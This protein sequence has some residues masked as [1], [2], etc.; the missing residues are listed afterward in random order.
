MSQY[1]LL[2]A[3]IPLS[4]FELFK[5]FKCT[6]KNTLCGISIGLV[7]APVGFSLLKFTYVPII[8]KF[9]G[10]IGLAIHLTHGWFGYA[11]MMSTGLLKTGIAVTALQF[12][13][14]NVL[15]GL[16]FA[17]IYAL[18]GYVL[19]RRRQNKIF[20]RKIFRKLSY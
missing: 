8:G 13:M 20:T 3:L 5:L 18:I 17:S 2:L 6:Y 7:V 15:N 9:V 11:C 16:L 19:D 12:T 10:L 4:C 1:L 14:I